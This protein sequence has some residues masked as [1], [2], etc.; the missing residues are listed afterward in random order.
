M[1]FLHEDH[2]FLDKSIDSPKAS[3]NKKKKS[4]KKPA[5]RSALKKSERQPFCNPQSKNVK[6]AK[7]LQS[8][9]EESSFQFDDSFSD[10]GSDSCEEFPQSESRAQ[11]ERKESSVQNEL[12]G[13][14]NEDSGVQDE[15]KIM[16]VLE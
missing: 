9:S 13:K 15:E 7:P 10:S 1:R 2:S 6:I 3:A 16:E 4:L 12:P 11:N 14:G 8:S 5:L